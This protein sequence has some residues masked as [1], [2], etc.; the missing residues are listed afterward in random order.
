MEDVYIRKKSTVFPVI[1]ADKK[2]MDLKRRI[3]QRKA[4]IAA[5]Q[6]AKEQEQEK[7]LASDRTVSSSD[8]ANVDNNSNQLDTNTATTDT[9]TNTTITTQVGF[10]KFKSRIEPTYQ[11]CRKTKLYAIKKNRKI[12]TCALR[13]NFRETYEI[14]NLL[15]KFG[16]HNLGFII[17]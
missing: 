2:I 13:R 8:P 16:I 14:S 10:L 7:L 5:E 9:K 12:L 17:Y 6:A 1:Q 15:F 4:E 11:L 3:D